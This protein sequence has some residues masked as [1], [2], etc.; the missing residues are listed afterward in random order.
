MRLRRRTLAYLHS[1][2]RLS[3]RWGTQLLFSR[4]LSGVAAR[5]P[6][7]WRSRPQSDPYSPQVVR[8]TQEF[9]AMDGTI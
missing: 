9:T 3:R 7:E 4:L 6:N 5:C 1:P 2:S 8:V